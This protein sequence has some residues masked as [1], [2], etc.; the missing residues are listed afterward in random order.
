MMAAGTLGRSAEGG[1]PFEALEHH[2]CRACNPYEQFACIPPWGDVTGTEMVVEHPAPDIP[3]VQQANKLQV[4]SG[5]CN[6]VCWERSLTTN[7]D[8]SLRLGT[9]RLHMAAAAVAFVSDTAV[10]AAA[11]VVQ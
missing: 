7:T 8:W 3:V 2:F 11:V 5:G 1:V 10:F 4:D 9:V 6:P